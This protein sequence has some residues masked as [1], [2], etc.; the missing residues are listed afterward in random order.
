MKGSFL[1]KAAELFNQNSVFE[2]AIVLKIDGEEYLEKGVL[3][4]SP[5]GFNVRFLLK[6]HSMREAEVF[7]I[8]IGNKF[9]NC[10]LKYYEE[11]LDPES[12][13]GI[14]CFNFDLGTTNLKTRE[15]YQVTKS[16]YPANIIS[17]YYESSFAQQR[18]RSEKV[19]V[20]G[21]TGFGFNAYYIFDSETVVKCINPNCGWT[22]TLI[23]NDQLIK[24]LAQIDQSLQVNTVNTKQEQKEDIFAW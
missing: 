15:N 22:T 8:Y 21:K 5:K 23:S 4:L 18:D 7:T 3:F 16:I 19:P 9:D 20:Y 10:S 13:E 11:G 14:F 2:G 24:D 17:Y 1:I 12:T 6:T